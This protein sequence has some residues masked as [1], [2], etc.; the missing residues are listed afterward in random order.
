MKAVSNNKRFTTLN[1]TEIFKVYNPRYRYSYNLTRNCIEAKKFFKTTKK[2][3]PQQQNS[4]KKKFSHSTYFQIKYYATLIMQK[5]VYFLY[6]PKLK[7]YYILLVIITQ[8]ICFTPALCLTPFEAGEILEANREEWQVSPSPWSAPDFVINQAADPRC[9]VLNSRYPE[10]IISLTEYL[11]GFDSPVG[12]NA[13]SDYPI[14][15]PIHG[16]PDDMKKRLLYMSYFHEA[17]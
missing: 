5:T 2:P 6:N 13:V 14:T 12:P 15:H 11:D 7:L 16:F 9:S 10:L 8:I 1:Q 17:L 4:V 3:V